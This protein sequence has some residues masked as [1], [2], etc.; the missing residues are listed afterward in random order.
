MVFEDVTG[1]KLEGANFD[2]STTLQLFSLKT[3]P[4]MG[5]IYGKTVREK[6][7]SHVHF[8]RLKGKKNRLLFRQI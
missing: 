8:L 1:V 3:E 5:L 2:S 6:V 4:T 7:Q